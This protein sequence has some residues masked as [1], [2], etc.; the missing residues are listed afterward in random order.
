MFGLVPIIIVIIVVVVILLSRSRKGFH[1]SRTEG[2]SATRRVWLY[3]I[4][5]ISLGIFAAGVEQLLSL[6]FEVA[7][8]GSRLTQVGQAAFNQQQLSLGLAMTLIGGPLWFFFWRVV[9][10]RTTGNQAETGDIIRKLYLNLVLVVPALMGIITASS[11]LQWLMAGV[12]AEQLSPSNLALMIVAGFIWGY[13]WWLS[14]HEGHPSSDAKTL[15]RWYVY[16]LSGFS[17]VWLAVG[18]V[19]LVDSAVISLPLG[20][21]TLVQAPFW[22]DDARFSIARIMLGGV[23]WYFHWFR[24]AKGDLDSTLR[25]VYF[26]LLAISGGAIAALVALTVALYRV[27][28]WVFGGTLTATGSTFQFL[29][30]AVPTFLIGVAIWGYHWRLAEEEAG[31]MGEKRQS[32]QRGYNYLM[33]FLGLGTLVTGLSMIFGLLVDLI[34]NAAGPPLTPTTY[35]WSN[36]LAICLA[37]LL[38]GTPI[39]LYYWNGILKRVQAGGII[40]RHALPRRVFLYLIIGVSIVALAA[41]LVNIIY[42]ILNGTLQGNL[43]INVVRSSKWSIE[44]LIVAAPLLWYHWRL[45]R[46][47]QLHGGE[48]VTVR[49]NI[50]F[51]ADDLTRELASRLENKLGYKIQ[52]FYRVGQHAENPVAIPDEEIDKL[53]GEVQNSLSNDVLLV[54]YE[55]KI[56]TIPYRDK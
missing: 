7:I 56:I 39:W 11:F 53:A 4:T 13:H 47:D 54:V 6:L 9:Q 34:I 25:Q 17:M 22:G 43:G 29:G 33:S 27:F 19:Q 26:Y 48:S 20:K 18:L 24:M 44:T 55:G 31:S 28:N 1:V 21:G 38:V 3:L 40:E 32:A 37:L 12:P 41:D 14:E 23:A 46:A 35:W 42:Q 50:T 16:I 36:Q 49:R 2:G 30:W 52:V 8:K 15:R 5:L 51:M 10:R 45:L